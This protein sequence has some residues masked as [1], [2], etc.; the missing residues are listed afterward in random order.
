MK[1]VPSLAHSTL[2]LSLA[3]VAFSFATE[4]TTAQPASDQF[5]LVLPDVPFEQWATITFAINAPDRSSKA[6]RPATE[7]EI[8]VAITTP[9]GLQFAVPT[10]QDFADVT[11]RSLKCRFTPREAGTYRATITA[12]NDGKSDG[13]TVAFEVARSTGRQGFLKVDRNQPYIMVFDN[14]EQFRGIGTNL[15]WEPRRRRNQQYTYD[16]LFPR[17][18]SHG[19]NIVRTWMCPW[20]MPMEWKSLGEYDEDA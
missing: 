9:S 11:R 5:H 3:V 14:G 7:T 20:N 1:F 12:A 16:T 10:F 19:L 8:D 4:T 18:A 17:I 2:C 13:N 15:G 6:P